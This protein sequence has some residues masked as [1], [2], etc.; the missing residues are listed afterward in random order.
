MFFGKLKSDYYKFSMNFR[1]VCLGFIRNC[2]FR[3]GGGNTV[4]N[5][6]LL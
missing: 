4:N 5:M 3:G 1:V 2:F 6:F